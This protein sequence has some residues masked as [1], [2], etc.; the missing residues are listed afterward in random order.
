LERAR[1]LH[2]EAL[3]I[4]RELVGWS[5]PHTLAQLGCAEARLGELDQADEHLREAA[6]LVLNAFEPATAALVLVG[7]A[8]VALGRNRPERSALLLGAA[9]AVHERAGVTAVGTAQV[10]ADAARRAAR[11]QLGPDAY[12]TAQ[13]T[14]HK[15]GAAALRPQPDL[16]C[17][18]S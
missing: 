5:V 14:G 9:D 16:P 4:V 6:D 11:D 10:E 17:A 8:L 15:L 7:Q 13:A 1:E 2:R 3:G 18:S 12:R